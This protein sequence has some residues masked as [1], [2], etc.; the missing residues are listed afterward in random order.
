MLKKTIDILTECAVSLK[1]GVN[2]VTDFRYDLLFRLFR[3]DRN[4]PR[5]RVFSQAGQEL[6]AKYFLQ[7]FF[8]YDFMSGSVPGLRIVDIGA[9]HPI[10]L[11][12]TYLFEKLFGAEVYSFEPNIMLEPAWKELRPQSKICFNGIASKPDTLELHIPEAIRTD[13][14]YPTHMLASFV[15]DRTKMNI[16]KQTVALNTLSHFIDPGHYSLLFIDVD[17][18]E[19]E[20]LKGIDFSQFSFD[21][22]FLENNDVKGGSDAHRKF[23]KERGYRFIARISRLDDVYIRE[24]R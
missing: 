6:I 19:A 7:K 20:V 24:K 8:G 10:R 4:L 3:T 21:V 9:N 1:Y 13:L 15:P 5:R 23:M 18:F 22:V 16:R 14:D 11:N 2:V 17:G 12:N